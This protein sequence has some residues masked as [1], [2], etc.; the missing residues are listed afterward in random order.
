LPGTGLY[1]TEY[2]PAAPMVHHGHRLALLVAVALV[3]A[4]IAWALTAAA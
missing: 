2:H 4:L 1:W 3:G